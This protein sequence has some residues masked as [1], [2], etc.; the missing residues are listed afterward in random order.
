MLGETNL[1]EKGIK[2]GILLVVVAVLVLLFW[3]VDLVLSI[4][5]PGV[6]ADVVRIIGKMSLSWYYSW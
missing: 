3:V 1:K 4:W 2:L 5:F 6:V